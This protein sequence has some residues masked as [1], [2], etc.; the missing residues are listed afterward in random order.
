MLTWS[1]SSLAV[2]AL[3]AGALSPCAMPS[4]ARAGDKIAFSAP[5]ASLQVPQVERDDK[6]PSTSELQKSMLAGDLFPTSIQE[7]SEIVIISTPRRN[8]IK[9]RDSAFTDDWDN[10]TDEDSRYDNDNLDPRQRPIKGATN[11]WNMPGGWNPDAESIYS[12]RRSDEAASQ[13]TLR[14][15]L[16]AESIAERAD[17]QRDGRYGRRSS[18]SDEDPKWSRSVSHHGSSGLERMREGQFVPFYEEIK[19]MKEQP[20]PGY[21]STRFSSA[22]DDLQRDSTL[23]PEAA[24][25]ASQRGDALGK[26]PDETVNAPRTIRPAERTTVSQNPDVS[27]RQEPPA[28]PRGQ[29]QSRPAILPFPKKP[30]SVFY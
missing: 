13:D 20:N 6:E 12:E 15:R 21:S 7:S 30:G 29:V 5:D 9:K 3:V 17:Y 22:Q 11:R 24:R 28:S 26:T 19:S 1:S 2:L 4:S 27:E 16:E 10:D 25:Y 14:A 8:D 23:S 18:D